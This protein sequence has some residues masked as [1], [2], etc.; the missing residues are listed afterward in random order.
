GGAEGAGEGRGRAAEVRGAKLRVGELEVPFTPAAA[1]DLDGVAARRG[2]D[3]DG[4]L[5]APLLRRYVVEVDL[6]AAVLK[7]HDPARWR[8]GGGGEELAVRVDAMGTPHVRVGFGMPGGEALEGE[9]KVDSAASSATLMFAQPFTARHGLLDKLRAAGAPLLADELGGVGGTSRMWYTRLAEARVGR[10]AFERPWAGV[11]EAKGGTLAAE[12]I[13]GIIG[14]GL[15]H[16]Y[17]VIYDCPRGRIYL[18]QGKRMGDPFEIDMSGLRWIS[19]RENRREH[20]V[21]AVM[22]G[23]P[24]A[25]AGL[26]VGDV[27]LRVDGRRAAEFDRAALAKRLMSPGTVRLQV[28]REG[29]ELEFA[30]A[31]GR[32]V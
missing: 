1:L 31:L 11:I 20:R 23:S 3:L 24:A 9:F 10:T 27:L 5:G 13:A 8:Y 15:M 19:P 4:L 22:D 25:R 17:K 32:L 2:E 26:R 28:M 7:I 29:R 18:E 21:R 14:G 6:E 12:G 16:R 30:L